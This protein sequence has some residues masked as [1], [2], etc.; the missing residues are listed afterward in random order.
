MEGGE[1]WTVVQKNKFA[2]WFHFYIHVYFVY[3][4]IIHETWVLYHTFMFSL[5]QKQEY[6][7]WVEDDDRIT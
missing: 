3:I 4:F 2:L 6:F 7:F 5:W 1:S